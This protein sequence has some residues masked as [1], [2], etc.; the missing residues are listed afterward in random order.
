MNKKGLSERDICTKF[1]TPT[2]K[3]AGAK[4]RML[5]L[6]DR[7]ALIDRTGKGDFRYFKDK[8]TVVKQRQIDKSVSITEIIKVFGSCEVSD[9]AIRELENE[10]Y[11]VA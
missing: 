11:K 7:N 6:A 4:K 5:F 1:F 10:F 8:M 3:N 2:L 9:N